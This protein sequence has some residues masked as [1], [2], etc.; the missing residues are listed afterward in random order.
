M[1]TANPFKYIL[2]IRQITTNVL[3]LVTV[4]VALSLLVQ[5]SSYAVDFKIPPKGYK[6]DCNAL[7]GPCEGNCGEDLSPEELS[8]CQGCC[9]RDWYICLEKRGDA[10]NPGDFLQPD[11]LAEFQVQCGETFNSKTKKKA[12]EGIQLLK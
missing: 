3:F 5:G 6:T 9:K 4:T 10:G 12:I 8:K 7:K 1:T 2:P 11:D